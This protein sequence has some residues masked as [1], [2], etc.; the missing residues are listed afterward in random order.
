MKK[1][2]LL[3]VALILTGLNS[4]MAAID[5]ELRSIITTAKGVELTEVTNDANN[6]WTIADGVATSTVGKMSSTTSQTFTIKFRAT[7][8]TIFSYGFT[9]DFHP[10]GEYDRKIVTFDD[11]T[12]YNN[13][14]NSTTKSYYTHYFILDE[15]EHTITFTH[16]HFSNSN[17]NNFSQVMTVSDIALYTA[18]SQMMTIDLAAPGT[19]GVEALNLVNTLPAMQFLRLSGKLNAD[20]WSSIKNMTGLK[21]ID[22]TNAQIT[23]IPDNAFSSSQLRFVDLPTCLKTIGA[24]AFYK[25]YLTGKLTLPAMLE[26]IGTEAFAFNNITEV[27]IPDNV[28]SMDTHV[29]RDNQKLIT[30]KLGTGLT[31]LNT[32]SFYNC[33]ALK[34]VSG[35]ANVKTIY[36]ECF[37]SCAALESASDL[38]PREVKGYAFNGAKKLQSF[39]FADITDLGDYAFRNCQALKSVELPKISYMSSGCF[40]DCSSITTVKLGDKIR[41]IPSDAFNGCSSLEEVVLGSSVRELGSYCF[42]NSSGSLKRVYLAAPAPPST[43]TSPFYRLSGVTLYV[44]DYAMISYKQHSYWSQFTSVDSNPNPAGYIDLYGKLELSTNSRIPNNPD[45]TMKYQGGSTPIKGILIVNGNN[46]QSLGNYYHWA[47]TSDNCPVTISRCN[48]MTAASVK[49][50]HYLA[51]NY[52]YYITMPFDVK[53]SDITIS[54]GAVAVRYYDADSRAQNGAG[55]NWKDVADDAILREGQGYIFCASDDSWCQFTASDDTRNHIFKS[56]DVTLTLQE[57]ASSVSND[58]NWNLVGNPYPSFFDI[59]YMDYTAPITLWDTDN[60]TFTAKSVADDQVALRPFQAFFVQKP[61]LISELTFRTDG[62]QATKTIDRSAAA[63]RMTPVVASRR[64]VELAI[65]DG[66]TTDLTRVVVNHAASDDFCADNDATKMMADGT[67]PQIYTHAAG[68]IYAIN[69]G[70][71]QSGSVKVGVQ[72]AHSGTYTI[73]MPRNDVRARLYDYGVEVELP[74]TFA[75]D[76][77]VEDNRFTI[78]F[79]TTTTGIDAIKPGAQADGAIYTLDGI[80]VSTTAP[81]GIYIQNHKKIVK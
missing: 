29:F 16:K 71:H 62:R 42:Y 41:Y 67:T 40:N 63:P 8:R 65:T 25:R 44:P 20:D 80:R 46:P 78:G 18:E 36:N 58:A 69:E 14:S 57:H 3:T 70:A 38:Q 6:P 35:G 31:S 81:K 4:A 10:Y 15:G 53:R 17:N 72:I 39:N 56:H 55:N 66:S 79:D 32:G 33:Q 13:Y 34:T 50:N 68:D 43:S 7:G 75:A 28:T 47:D 52:W 1:T 5:D 24:Q 11:N 64:F 45:I 19:L 76:E 23:D 12:L 60:R 9:T 22:L 74:Y 21:C 51:N 27:E 26:K 37:R 77:G 48:Q 59:Y 61:T 2:L 73:T 54:Q 49:V 30:A